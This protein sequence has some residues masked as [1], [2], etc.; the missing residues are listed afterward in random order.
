MS[1]IPAN[2]LSACDLSRLGNNLR[3]PSRR[4]KARR[5]QVRAVN[6]SLVRLGEQVRTL[7]PL[8]WPALRFVAT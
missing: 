5:R 2:C 7:Y 3:A 6:R 8:S 1:I 4:A